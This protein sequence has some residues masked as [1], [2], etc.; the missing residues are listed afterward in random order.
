MCKLLH[1]SI[2]NSNHKWDNGGIIQPIK[3]NTPMPE[4]NGTKKNQ[5]KGGSNETFEFSESI[6]TK[7]RL[8]H[9]FLKLPR[10]SLYCI[11]LSLT[12]VRD[13]PGDSASKEYAMQ[14]TQVQSLGW[15]DPLEKGMVTH[16]SILAWRI[17]WTDGTGE[18]QFMGSQRVGHNSVTNTLLM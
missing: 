5:M 17:P 8:A 10:F 1:Y 13:F 12:N 9:K 2:S 11:S 3:Q 14:E 4:K 7:V 16:S 18:L 6:N 15:E